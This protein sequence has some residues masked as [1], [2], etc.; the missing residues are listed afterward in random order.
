MQERIIEIIV[1]LL[2]HLNQ[3]RKGRDKFDLTNELLVKGYTDVEI[4]LAFSWLFN[5]LKRPVTDRLDETRQYAEDLEDYP[6]FEEL[7]ISPDAYGYFLQL[8]Q[9]GVIKEDD[10]EMFIERAV[11]FGKDDI[12]VDDLKSI[13]ASILFGFDNRSSFNGYP[14]YQGDT[15]FQ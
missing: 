9:L 1:Y 6:E 12:S 14:S 5:H 2:S 4:N 7:V 13:V 8:V 3:E 15:I 11:A 10:I